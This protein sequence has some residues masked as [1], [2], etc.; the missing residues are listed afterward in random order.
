MFR[1]PTPSHFLSLPLTFSVIINNR[2]PFVWAGVIDF[3]YTQVQGPDDPLHVQDS[4]YYWVWFVVSIHFFE[5]TVSI[6]LKIHTMTIPEVM[7]T[8]T[9]LHYNAESHITE[10]AT[11]LSQRWITTTLH[12]SKKLKV[13]RWHSWPFLIP[14]ATTPQKL[15]YSEDSHRYVCTRHLTGTSWDEISELMRWVVSR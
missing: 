6:G 9:W 13:S 12:N 1:T 11:S 2:S 15:V 10:N 8:N 3:L 7:T 4:N 5:P 14:F